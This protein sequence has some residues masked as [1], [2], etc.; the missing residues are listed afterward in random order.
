MPAC[1]TVPLPCSP[2]LLV[3][4]SLNLR[5]LPSPSVRLPP[6]PPS[7]PPTPPPFAGETLMGY[8]EFCTALLALSA[9]KFADMPLP[10]A[11]QRA[12]RLIIAYDRAHHHIIDQAPPAPALSD[13]RD[14]ELRVGVP[15]PP[16][17]P[18]PH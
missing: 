18:L 9:R 15:P 10:A 6:T 1:P 16:P 7:P 3:F 5:F 13:D 11:V 2:P 8:G 12:I 14:P 17:P 4:F